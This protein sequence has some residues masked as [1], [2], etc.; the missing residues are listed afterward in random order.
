MRILQNSEEPIYQQIATKFRGQILSG[1]IQEGS[2]LPSVLGLAQN[3]KISVITTMKAYKT[4]AGEGL[5]T[6]VQGER[7]SGK[8]AEPRAGEGT[9]PVAGGREFTDDDYVCTYCGS[10]R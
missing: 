9:A 2:Y 7:F 5:V 4:L 1:T 6:A 10:Y 3:L 8:C